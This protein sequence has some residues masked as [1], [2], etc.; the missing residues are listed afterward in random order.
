[1]RQAVSARL[2]LHEARSVAA[3]RALD[4]RPLVEELTEDVRGVRATVGELTSAIGRIETAL[5]ETQDAL[6]VAKAS[7]LRHERLGRVSYDD[8][9]RLRAGLTA[10]RRADAY[11]AV[12]ELERPLVSVPIA[13]YNAAELLVERA[14][15]SVQA[16]TYTEWEIVVVGDGCTDDTADRIEALADPRIRFVN[17]PFR[18]LDADD[19]RER[20]LVS[21]S[22]P[23]NLAVELS[24][25]EWLA[26]LDDDDEFLPDHLEVLLGLARTRRAELAYG[27]IVRPDGHEHFAAP[28]APEQIGMQAVLYLRSLAMV[29]E[30]DTRSWVLDE[31]ADWNLIRRMREA[32]VLMA[33]TDVPVTR[34]YPSFSARV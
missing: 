2:K 15:P 30:W 5:A 28:P 25:G 10:L 31:P 21:G 26:P 33:A 32:G 18:T 13:T 8:L 27:K 19:A 6:A 1:M 9:G 11:E 17:L 22:A 4:L 29:F 23:Q 3:T 20:W 14:I 7:A 16:Q 12:F 34:Y 24:G